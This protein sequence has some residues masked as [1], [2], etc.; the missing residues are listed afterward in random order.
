MLSEFPTYFDTWEV[1]PMKGWK[2]K[3]ADVLSNYKTEAGTDE[4]NYTRKDKLTI[5]ASTVGFDYLLQK[6]YQFKNKD[7]FTLKM[8][9]PINKRYQERIVRITSFGYDLKEKTDKI[10]ISNGIYSISFTVEEF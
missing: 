7:S 1:P 6:L 4:V 9:N 10:S 3:S 2:I 8:Y 5:S